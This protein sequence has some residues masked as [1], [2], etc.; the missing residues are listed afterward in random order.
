M[1]HVRRRRRG[2]DDGAQRQPENDMQLSA[3]PLWLVGFRPFYA[4][5][6]L[7]GATP[8]VLWA[9]LYMGAIAAPPRSFSLVQWHAHAMFLSFGWA[10]FGSFLL[11]AV[12]AH[13]GLNSR[14]LRSVAP[15]AGKTWR[16]TRGRRPARVRS[17]GDGRGLVQRFARLH[18]LGRGEGQVTTRSFLEPLA[19]QF[20]AACLVSASEFIHPESRPSRARG[21]IPQILRIVR[22]L[23]T[24]FVESWQATA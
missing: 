8:P 20:K 1:Q 21:G 10:V 24:G 7:S 18:A 13:E 3:H 4:L 5:A 11:A 17:S 2:P 15:G 9:L 19:P 16:I 23:P 22:R 14:G 12:G 6:C